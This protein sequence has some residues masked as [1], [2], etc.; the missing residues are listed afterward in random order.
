MLYEVIT[1]PPSD[2]LLVDQRHAQVAE[3]PGSEHEFNA[4]PLHALL[5]HEADRADAPGGEPDP[6]RGIARAYGAL[7]DLEARLTEP[8]Y[9]LAVETV[10]RAA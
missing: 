3:G 8:A 2:V 7:F 4:A 9:D 10:E 5:E 1:V 6:K